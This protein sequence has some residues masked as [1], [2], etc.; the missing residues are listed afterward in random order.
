MCY[1]SID[2]FMYLGLKPSALHFENKYLQINIGMQS[3]TFT[4]D[5][6]Q[7]YIHL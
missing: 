3:Q 5:K 6:W 4:A 2:N 1:D 7:N